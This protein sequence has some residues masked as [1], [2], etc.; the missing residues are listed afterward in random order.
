MKKILTVALMLCS[1]QAMAVDVDA[2]RAKAMKGD[3]Q[4]QRNL[5]YTLSTGS[6]SAK[7]EN[8][9]LGCAWYKVILLSGSEK[10]H[11]GDIGNVKVYCGKLT[12]DQQGVADSQARRLAKEI[13]TR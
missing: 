8:P 11:D 4:A 10:V 7:S 9:M 13:Y 5:A 2:L 3:Y 12:P 6:G 1:L